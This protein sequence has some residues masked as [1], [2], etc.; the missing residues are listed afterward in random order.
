MSLGT[1][2]IIHS[3]SSLIGLQSTIH[4]FDGGYFILRLILLLEIIYRFILFSPFLMQLRK[5]F[6]ENS[7]IRDEISICSLEFANK[8]LFPH[9]S[10]SCIQIQVLNP[11]TNKLR[12]ANLAILKFS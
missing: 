5:Y 10:E 7:S 9:P 2:M 11:N 4:I 12:L 3:I 6:G 8:K 1:L